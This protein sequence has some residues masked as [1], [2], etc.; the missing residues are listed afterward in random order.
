MKQRILATLLSFLT[1]VQV[2]SAP[3]AMAIATV[4]NIASI[5]ALSSDKGP[6]LTGSADGTKIISAGSG[7]YLSTNS[8]VSFTSIIP[9]SWA[10]TTATKPVTAAWIS[11]DGNKIIAVQ[12]NGDIAISVN[13]GSTWSFAG[14]TA[15]FRDVSASSTMEKIYAITDGRT[16]YSSTDSG[17]TWSNT[18]TGGAG[19]P[20]TSGN[21]GVSQNFASVQ[22][23]STGTN[24]GI[25]GRNGFYRSTDSG[26]TWT[27]TD[28]ID[29]SNG[30]CCNYSAM[31]T[32]LQTILVAD[33][34]KGF[35]LSKNYGVSFTQIPMATFEKMAGQSAVYGY[36]TG[37]SADGTKLIA[38]NFG[39]YVYSSNDGGTTWVAETNA[40][41]GSWGGRAF[42]AN[43]GNAIVQTN[44][45]WNWV[46]NPTGL[47]YSL[48]NVVASNLSIALNGGGSRATY[49]T[50][51][52]ITATISVA[53]KVTFFAN[54][55]VI[56]GC[57][58]L[59]GTSSVQCNWKPS[60][61]GI[62]SITGRLLP[63]NNSYLSAA[64]SP[65]S[66][67]ITPRTTKR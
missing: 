9:S 59:L 21:F 19:S 13:S 18:S 8:G 35:Y 25:V 36:G 37:V 5:P 20:F 6:Y 30:S 23:T 62:V 44:A 38:H 54:G 65:L 48:T 63:T 66:V 41:Y 49:R 11:E 56:P 17:A 15:A 55:K 2:V 45:R 32:N 60:T 39:V 27:M 26:A 52:P 4:S 14:L 43:N 53:G 46:S 16:L 10:S 29:G 22:T 12:F 50:S 24:V 33:N 51:S 7:L 61:R 28:N 34:G 58:S 40:G 1:I 67:S 47:A 31:S 42:V 64:A 3:Q 57:N